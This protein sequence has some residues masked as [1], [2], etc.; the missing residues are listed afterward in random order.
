MKINGVN[1]DMRNEPRN[2]IAKDAMNVWRVRAIINI[3]ICWGLLLAGGLAWVYFFMMRDFADIPLFYGWIYLGLVILSIVLFVFIVPKFRYRRWRYEIFEQEVYIQHGILIM[4]R[5]IVPMIR[6]Q[7]VDTVQG[8]ILKKYKLSTVTISTAATVHQIPAL[9]DE[10][11]SALR[12]QIS[13]LARVDE[14]DM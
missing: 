14:D 4:T 9:T 6:V 11:A 5:T 13:V 12:D 2:R 1:M 10:D 3:I 8:P 7:H